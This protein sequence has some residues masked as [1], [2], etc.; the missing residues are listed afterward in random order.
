MLDDIAIK[1]LLLRTA[2][3]DEGSAEAFERLFKMCAPLLLGVAKRIVGRQ[4]LAEDVLQDSFAKIW[5]LAER[6]DPFANQPVAWMVAIVRNRAIDVRASHAESRVDSYHG[7]ANANSD[8]NPDG[9]LDALLD[10]VDDP[11]ESADQRRIA[12]WLRDCLGGLEAVERQ[13]LVLAYQQGMSHG[14]LASHLDKPLGTVKTWVRRGMGRLRD[15]VQA[16][17]GRAP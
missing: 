2:A 12:H 1:R 15:C 9:N 3:R 7:T 16:R 5:G 10:S 17:M 4:E 8:A 11:G 6:F 13:S 14:E